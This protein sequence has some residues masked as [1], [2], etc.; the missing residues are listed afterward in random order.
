MNTFNTIKSLFLKRLTVEC[1][2]KFDSGYLDRVVDGIKNDIIDKGLGYTEHY[3]P[4]PQEVLLNIFKLLGQVQKVVEAR[5][6]RDE[7]TYKKLVLELPLEV[8][9]CYNEVLVL[10]VQFDITLFAFPMCLSVPPIGEK[11]GKNLGGLV[12]KRKIPKMPH[13]MENWRDVAQE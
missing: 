2:Y 3:D 10:G 13:S 6:A 5:I 11:F 8:Q 9:N 12:L 7:E 4:I 1:G